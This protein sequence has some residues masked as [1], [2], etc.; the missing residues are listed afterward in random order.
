[1][2][3]KLERD[4][5]VFMYKAARLAH[6]KIKVSSSEELSDLVGGLGVPQVPYGLP[7]SNGDNSLHDEEFIELCLEEKYTVLAWGPCSM[8]IMNE[9]GKT[10][11]TVHCA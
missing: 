1:M 11:D 6:R 3:I 10:V 8:F 7:C 2:Y 9:S 5:I 4:G